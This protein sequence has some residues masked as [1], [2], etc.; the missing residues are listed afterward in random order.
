M[1]EAGQRS[2]VLVSRCKCHLRI[3]D[4]DVNQL[5]NRRL[6]VHKGPSYIIFSGLPTSI[7][8]LQFLERIFELFLGFFD[9]QT[10]EKQTFSKVRC[11]S[12]L[13]RTTAV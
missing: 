5:K 7:A 1:D 2:S 11:M 3:L 12:A 13:S 4:F 10:P 9:H 8:A 6:K